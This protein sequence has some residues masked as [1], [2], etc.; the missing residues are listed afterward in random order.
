MTRYAPGIAIAALL[1]F[2]FTSMLTGVL[3]GVVA[4]GV[5]AVER[6]TKRT[7]G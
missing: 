6:L 5:Y 4:A 3:L 2:V 7:E 1:V